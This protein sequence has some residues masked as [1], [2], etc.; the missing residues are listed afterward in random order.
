MYDPHELLG[1]IDANSGAVLV[2]FGV[3]SVFQVWWLANAV[4]VAR[5]D[6]AYSIPL[7][8][9]Y[10]W[11]AHDFSVVARFEVWFEV[12]DHWYL[13]FFWL[14]L[15]IANILEWFFLWQVYKY[16]RKELVPQWSPRSF[17]AL[18]FVGLLFAC[19]THE[20]FKAAFGDPLFQLDP[21]LTMLAYPAFGAALLIRRQ[22]SRGQTPMMWWM[23]TAMTAGFHLITYRWFGEAF[24]TWQYVA[25]GTCATLG[26]AAMAIVLGLPRWRWNGLDFDGKPLHRGGS[27][28]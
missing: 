4:M 24:R 17:A 21:T 6:Q 3:D 5:R 12:Y 28:R 26:G 1:L 7:F 18:L 19:V 15:L 27:G 2:A 9:T 16:G 11:F 10:F 25:A 20:F 23:F 8:C 14:V 13:K 22:S